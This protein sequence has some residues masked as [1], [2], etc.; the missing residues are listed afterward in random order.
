MECGLRAKIQ[1][2]GLA[3]NLYKF[4]KKKKPHFIVKNISNILD[5]IK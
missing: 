4:N 1:T 3:N 2:I 5:I